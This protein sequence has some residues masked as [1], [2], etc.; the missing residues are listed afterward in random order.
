MAS[1]FHE[2]HLV[3]KVADVS[4]AGSG[5]VTTDGVDMAGYQGCYFISSY[6]TAA[7]NNL[8]Y[9]QGSNDDGSGDSYEDLEGTEVGVGSSD[10]D[11]WAEI[12]TPVEQWVRAVYER[13][14]SSTLGDI[15]CIRYG[16][17]SIPQDNTT[18]GTIYGE[19]HISPAE[20]TK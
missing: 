11:V 19:A 13:G 14:T 12:H 3:T 17:R 7:S 10:E 2:R 9:L 16:A 20:G 4:G 1:L 6:G 8:P 15:W 5:D 18:T